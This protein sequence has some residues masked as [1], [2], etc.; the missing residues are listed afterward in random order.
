VLFHPDEEKNEVYKFCKNSG[1][2]KCNV[3]LMG[4]AAFQHFCDAIKKA[5]GNEKLIIDHQ[6]GR[7]TAAGIVEDEEAAAKRLDAQAVVAKAKAVMEAFEKL[8]ANV[9]RDWTNEE[10]RVLGHVVFSPP[11]SF[12]SPDGGFTKDFAVIKINPQMVS[13]AN[14]VANAINVGSVTVDKLNDWMYP[15][16]S[17]PTSFKYPNNRLLS[18][19]RTV[20][21]NKMYKPDPKTKDQHND[22]VL[23]VMKNGNKTGL[24]VGHLNTIRAFVCTYF[25]GQPGTMSKEI[26]VLPCS[27]KSGA[28]SAKGNSGFVMSGARATTQTLN[29]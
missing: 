19:S 26:A 6:A 27:S 16:A 17:N 12:N 21:D 15:C 9:N 10:D 24:T 23:M 3:L 4:T 2:A 11:I 22:P 8:L 18:F 13:K 25:K 14:F 7:I 28:F 5:I 29:L 1:K 20:P